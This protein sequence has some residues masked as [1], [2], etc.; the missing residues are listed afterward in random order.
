MFNKLVVST[1]ER[2][3]KR[4]TRFFFGTSIVYLIV[5]AGGLAAS[6]F[7]ADPKLAD[8][9]NRTAIIITPTPP[10]MLGS[11]RRESR[12]QPSQPAPRQDL[13]NVSRLEDI[14][15]KPQSAQ[16]PAKP[17]APPGLDQ[18][19]SIGDGFGDPNGVRDGLPLDVAVPVGH[20]N[21]IDPP[22]PPDPPK[23]Q[24]QSRAIEPDRPV[25]LA[26]TVL[27]GKAIARRTPE[28]PQIAR[29]ARLQ[30]SVSVEVMIAP[31][32]RVESARA[33]SGHPVF[34]KAAV[35]STYG[36]RFEPTLLNGTAVRVT[37]IIVFNF[38]LS[39]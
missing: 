28:Y 20:T 38:R 8:S 29:Q 19:K 36:W 39:E 27:Q 17:F 11:T 22:R 21:T 12:N 37:G 32:G 23:P 16:T 6:V 9:N 35:D 18:G 24:A 13:N 34:A 10:R 2:R 3:G 25:R 31:D 33:V 5:I 14:L 7:F 1:S 26:S 30:G 15:A 4:T